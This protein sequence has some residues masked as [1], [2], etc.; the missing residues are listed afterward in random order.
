MIKA[1]PLGRMNHKE[2]QLI[3]RIFSNATWARYSPWVFGEE[4]CIA[5]P[6]PPG[7]PPPLREMYVFAFFLFVEKACIRPP[8]WKFL[9]KTLR[10]HL[11]GRC[12]YWKVK[13]EEGRKSTK[14]PDINLWHTWPSLEQV[15]PS[16]S[17]LWNGSKIKVF[18]WNS[19]LSRYILFLG[20]YPLL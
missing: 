7:A 13:C 1:Q 11:G 10:F 6:R 16:S 4:H 15:T 5:P 19:L 18:K 9:E 17:H 20:L 8:L 2:D 14:I 12:R 3:N